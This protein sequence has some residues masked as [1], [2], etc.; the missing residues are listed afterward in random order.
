MNISGR[1]GTKPLVFR[2]N[3]NSPRMAKKPAQPVGLTNTT[4]ALS[5]VSASSYA[6]G[7]TILSA[8]LVIARQ[9]IELPHRTVSAGSAF[10][11]RPT[12][13]QP[14]SRR[15][16]NTGIRTGTERTH[17]RYAETH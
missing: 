9:Q 2:K 6:S 11:Y 16:V 7:R 5:F 13:A 1:T 4:L 8:F 17:R 3:Q 12:G 15:G 14:C 10:E